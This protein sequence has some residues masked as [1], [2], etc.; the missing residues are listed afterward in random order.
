MA[1]ADRQKWD[2]IFSNKSD[3]TLPSPPQFLIPYLDQLP[4]GRSLD[5]ASG[6]GAVS[7]H[8]AAHHQVTALD[9][10]SEALK[11]QQSFADTSGLTI[12]TWQQDLDALESND[13]LSLF[14]NLTILRYK[15]SATQWPSLVALLKPHGHLLIATFN[16]AHHEH[17]GFNQHY[18]LAPDELVVLPGVKL[19]AHSHHSQNDAFYD[20]YLFQKLEDQGAVL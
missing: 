1:E 4:V 7:L 14:D 12:E 18:C 2:R 8:L 17:T 19:L 6:D 16:T 13:H 10:S 11:R 9:I 5:I 15:P 3:S 20:V